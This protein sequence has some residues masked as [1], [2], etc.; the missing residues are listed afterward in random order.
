MSTDPTAPPPPGPPSAPPPGRGPASGTEFFDRLR[1]FGAVRPDDGRWAAG[2][3]AALA[4]RAGVDPLLVRGVL[5]ALA[6]TSG[7]LALVG[8]GVAWALLPQQDG[9]IH[10][11]EAVH[12]RVRGGLVGAAVLALIGFSRPLPWW[13][14]GWTPWNGGGPGGGLVVLA[15]VLL[16][17]WWLSQR[18]GSGPGG[19]GGPGGPGGPGPGGPGGAYGPGAPAA[20][21]PAQ[22]PTSTFATTPTAAYP[23]APGYG[24]PPAGGYPDHGRYTTDATD[25]ADRYAAEYTARYTEAY[26]AAVAARPPDPTAP[27]HRLTLGTLGVALLAGGVLAVWDRSAEALPGPTGLV[28]GCAALA[29]VAAGIVVAGVLGLRAGGLA[30]VGVLLALGLIVAAV[31]SPWLNL[32]GIGE[33][34]WRPV[35]AADAEQGYQLGVGRLSADLSRTGLLAGARPEDPVTVETSL[36]VGELDLLVPAGTAVEIRAE[37]GAGDVQNGVDGSSESGV[38]GS[39]SQVERTIRIGTGDPL[40]VVHAKVGLGSV[41]VRPEPVTP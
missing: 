34:E 20:T 21:D 25:Y 23:T 37:V 38:R 40:L 14:A 2:V 24:T 15:L 33:R 8:Y 3:C 17:I 13:L 29:V 35:S 39:G 36:G 31:T 7:G 5:V 11:E 4:R 26:Q 19:W 30:P 16:G 32:S 18:N 1:G 6:L 12:G 27:S 9:T 22:A 28:A 41:Q 10:L